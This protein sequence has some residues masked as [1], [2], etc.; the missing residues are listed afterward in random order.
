MGLDMYLKARRYMSAYSYQLAADRIASTATIEEWG[1]TR[2][3]IGLAGLEPLI[4][5]E[6]Q[7][8]RVETTLVYWRKA[9]AI[10]GW[11]VEQKADGIDECQEIYLTAADLVELRN[12]C[13]VVLNTRE[14]DEAIVTEV[15]KRV[16][17]APTEGFFFGSY[18]YDDWYFND[19][20]ETVDKLDKVLA[21]ADTRPPATYFIYQASW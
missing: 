3:I 15:A 18:E 21:A 13:Q 6:D 9:N 12:A 7:S 11:F 2:A 1:R 16:G 4:Q 8:T 17:L 5:E 10:H 19:L 14:A 20:E